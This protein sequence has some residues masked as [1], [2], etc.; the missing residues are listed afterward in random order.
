MFCLFEFRKNPSHQFKQKRMHLTGQWSHFYSALLATRR[1]LF[2]NRFYF[3]SHF[4]VRKFLN[5]LR[6][7]EMAWHCY[8]QTSGPTLPTVTV[9]PCEM[10]NCCGKDLM[11]NEKRLRDRVQSEQWAA[12]GRTETWGK[13]DGGEIAAACGISDCSSGG[14]EGLM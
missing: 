1:V 12:A 6:T 5:D 3:S 7:E 11:T 8:P 14:T 4:T 9:L 2:K 13:R 10:R